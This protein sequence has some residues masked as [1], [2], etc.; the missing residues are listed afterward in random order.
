MLR[1]LNTRYLWFSS[2]WKN[3]VWHCRNG[4]ELSDDVA[5]FE[6][7]DLLIGHIASGKH[8]KYEGMKDFKAIKESDVLTVSIS[9]EEKKS[10]Q[11]VFQTRKARTGFEEHCKGKVW[12]HELGSYIISPKAPI[13][14]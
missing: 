13:D 11:W 6:E 8:R 12:I 1:N 3:G 5:E 9:G 4:L 10:V 14:A 7:K 2:A